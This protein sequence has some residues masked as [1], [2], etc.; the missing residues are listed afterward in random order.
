VRFSDQEER[1]SKLEI[2]AR[3]A[4]QLATAGAAGD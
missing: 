3:M 4:G 2:E 1:A